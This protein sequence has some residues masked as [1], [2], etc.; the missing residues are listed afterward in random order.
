M[1]R[2]VT[3]DCYGTLIDWNAGI[4]AAL[5]ALWPEAPTELLLETFHRVEPQVQH[6]RSIPYREVLAEA[7]IGVAAELDLAVRKDQAETFA[8][9]I[10]MWK[11]FREVAGALHAVRE[12]GWRTAIL[13]NCDADLLTASV[14]AI[15]VP[16]DLTITVEQSG[17]YKPEHGHWRTF[18]EVT[19]ASRASYAH[20]AASLFH[21][22]KPCAARGYPCV[23]VNRLHEIDTVTPRA[24]E[25]E[26]L[27][28]LPQTLERIR[29]LSA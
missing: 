25:I 11:P 10:G 23:W 14:K 22:V 12:A 19:N 18:F 28:S 8:L 24:A 21:D 9:S 26:D 27:S 3:F 17:S 20:V 16:F 13:S 4:A 5:H 15:G 1:E 2:W 7:A 6:G 29:F